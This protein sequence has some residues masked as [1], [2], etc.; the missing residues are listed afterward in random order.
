MEFQWKSNFFYYI[1]G[2]KFSYAK[3]ISFAQY[4][5]IYT[6]IFVT[7]NLN[8]IWMTKKISFPIFFLNFRQKKH[9]SFKLSDFYFF[10]QGRGRFFFNSKID[11]STNLG[12]VQFYF[13][14]FTGIDCRL[15]QERSTASRPRDLFT[16]LFF[17]NLLKHLKFKTVSLW[18]IKPFKLCA[19][20]IIICQSWRTNNFFQNYI[21]K[22][23]SLFSFSK[24]KEKR[25]L[26]FTSPANE[27]WIEK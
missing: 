26:I 9:L 15:K 24:T 6:Q 1:L 19:F 3:I 10:F 16:C 23:G 17:L 8:S 20:L 5:Y 18:D 27:K 11:H 7:Q 21:S 2:D 4:I 12:K 13:F 22:F 25:F 14:I